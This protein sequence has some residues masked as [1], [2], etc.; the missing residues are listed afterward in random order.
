MRPGRWLAVLLGTSLLVT[1]VRGGETPEIEVAY[2]A[3]TID[4]GDR[5][6]DARF[7]D[8]DADALPDLLTAVLVRRAGLP[9]R[10]ELRVHAMAPDGLPALQPT[11]IVPVPE[12]VIV[13]GCADVRDE[14]GRELL[15]MTR[16]GVYSY[17]LQREGL[18]ENVRR[19]ATMDLLYQVPSLRELPGWSYVI[20]RGE[21]RRDLLLLP[22]GADVTVWGPRAGPGEDASDYELLADLGGSER[23][24]LF[25]VKAPGA[26]RARAGDV[27]VSIDTGESRGL[28]LE[29]ALTA[30]EAMLQ[31]DV[32]YRAP[33]LFDVD[34]DGWV[35][36]LLY[37]NKQLRLHRGGPDGLPA[38]ATR[39]EALPEWLDRPDSD[40]ILNA[41]DLDGDGDVDLYAR[42]SPD[43]EGLEHV[44]FSYFV[45]IN[46]GQRLLPDEPDQVLRFEGSG[47][48]SEVTDVDA[49]GRPDLVVTKYELPQLT[50]LVT[51]FRFRRGAYVYLG[52]DDTPF[53]RRPSLRDEQVFTIESLQDALVLRRV[54]GDLSGDGIADLVEVDL[55]GHVAIRRIL[56]ER[57]LFGADEWR[58]EE[59]PWRRFDMGADLS[60][61]SLAD[62]NGDGFPD[63]MN[64]ADGQLSLLLSRVG[65]GAR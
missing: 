39:V 57:K 15:L 28:F 49:D 24:A 9:P 18:R 10:R 6:L 46:D 62:V 5:L 20:E 53:E 12:D 25:S 36:M 47:T 11:Q 50:D 23:A 30:F 59:T 61:L 13:Y 7:V 63:L 37:R 64:P 2:L 65:E 41:R 21:G 51:G 40:L 8:V 35:D 45:M 3:V 14:L 44:V 58:L 38:E 19:L 32:R 48:D 22:G 1:A 26:L 29:S 56:R 27:R 31:A 55:S 43:E 4:A 42:V 54:P 17:S 34:G 60:R 52:S 33:G 16:S